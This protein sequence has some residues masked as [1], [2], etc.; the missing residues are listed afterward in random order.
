ME[1]LNI[2]ICGS[3]S[4]TDEEK[5]FKIIESVLCDMNIGTIIT[6][7]A[8]GVDEIAK[9]W[10]IKKGIPHKQMDADWETY[11]K[12]AGPIRNKEM[13]IV[14]N[15][16][17]AIVDDK[18]VGTWNMIENAVTW[19]HVNITIFLWHKKMKLEFIEKLR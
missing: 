1:N 17:L 8:K 14:G 4:I 6:G 10:A 18:S 5:V 12:S 19:K 13:A 9:N 3:R 2:V 16:T 15:A 11:G 7:G